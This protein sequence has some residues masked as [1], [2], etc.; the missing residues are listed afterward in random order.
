[1]TPPGE[2]RYF[3]PPPLQ[4][5]HPPYRLSTASFSG[6]LESLFC[7]RKSVRI[8]L[9]FSL[10]SFAIFLDTTKRIFPDSGVPYPLVS[11]DGFA[12]FAIWARLH[13]A[14]KGHHL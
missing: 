4:I 7:D 12:I 9:L 2:N 6:S 3:R 1:M 8:A 14:Q 10:F 13:R 11:T 5:L